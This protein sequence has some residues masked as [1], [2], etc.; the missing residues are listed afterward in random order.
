MRK[1]GEVGGPLNE[2]DFKRKV[3]G[4]V[5]QKKRILET[6]YLRNLKIIKLRWSDDPLKKLMRLD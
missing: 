4:V 1:I 6:L 5:K 3:V 2:V